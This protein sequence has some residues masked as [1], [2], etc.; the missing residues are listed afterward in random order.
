MVVMTVFAVTPAIVLIEVVLIV[1][2][3]MVDSEAKFEDW[4]G[5]G[6]D[7]A[8]PA[9]APLVLVVANKLVDEVDVVAVDVLDTVP[10]VVKP[11]PPGLPVPTRVV[12]LPD[13]TLL[14]PS[15]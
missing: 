5:S 2:G 6:L 11:P 9:P 14:V 12:P 8:A 4:L 13:G 3:V 7:E 15:D 1:F 10:V